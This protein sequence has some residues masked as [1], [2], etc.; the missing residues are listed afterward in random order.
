[1][2]ASRLMEMKMRFVSSERDDAQATLGALDCKRLGP[3]S[4]AEPGS[5]FVH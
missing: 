1:M 4:G 2:K 3:C 5:P